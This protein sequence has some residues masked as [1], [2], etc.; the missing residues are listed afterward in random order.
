MLNAFAVPLVDALTVAE[1]FL[2]ELDDAARPLARSSLRAFRS[3]L[4]SLGLANVK[5][6]E[7]LPC[8]GSR[9]FA[10]RR[11]FGALVRKVPYQRTDIDR[12]AAARRALEESEL[13]CRRSNKRI[14][15][16]AERPNRL[17]PDVRVAMNR[18][19][20][21]VHAT[22]GLVTRGKLDRIKELSRPGGGVA[23]GTH[24]RYRVS[25]TYKYVATTPVGTRRA[26]PYGLA[27][28]ASRPKWLA[29]YCEVLEDGS[30][31]SV[32]IEEARGARVTFVPKDAKTLRSIAIEPSINVS[33]QLG[34]HEYLRGLLKTRCLQDIGDQTMNQQLA[35]L[36]SKCDGLDSL[37]TIDMSA[38]SDSISIELVRYLVPSCWFTL[39]DDLRSH[40]ISLDGEYR[41][42]EKFS[43]M[44][45]GFTFALETLLF[46]AL[47]EA[48][49]QVADAGYLTSV[50]GDDIIVPSACY[51]LL[52]EVFKHCGLKVNS[53]KSFVF[54]SFRESCGADW[55]A[56]DE[57]TPV[58]LREERLPRMS[59]YHVLNSWGGRPGRDRVRSCILR[60]LKETG[61]VHYGLENENT[62]G[63]VFT[64]L[65]ECKRLGAVR[66]NPHWQTYTFKALV[67][68]PRRDKSAPEEWRFLDSLL[69]GS[70]HTLT[71][72]GLTEIRTR[73][74]TPG[75]IPGV[76]WKHL[77]G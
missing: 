39:L 57:V 55:Y 45:N 27:L 43:T 63:C 70:R 38:A 2:P 8:S 13:R 10:T 40:E 9:E 62:S 23:I 46:W 34:V 29:Q 32:L 47:A 59:L 14:K 26:I 49:R 66:Y 1:S 77:A 51:A 76:R 50:Y 37:A 72:R 73:L 7:S 35:L 54:G 64:S 53:D 12:E 74:H 22:L 17:S 5:E 68:S 6:L 19:R 3:G 15:W 67:L 30:V 75:V 18:A 20:N 41:R 71:L 56:G 61:I 42:S 31:S 65:E 58:Y 16:Y 33:I 4:I 44:G 11:Q 60:K 25:P 48:C 52:L 21:L 69:S 36:G 28:L 24:N